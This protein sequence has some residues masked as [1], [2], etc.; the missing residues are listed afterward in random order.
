VIIFV[1]QFFLVICVTITIF[2][3]MFGHGFKH[4]Y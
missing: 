3:T 4:N 1:S 2:G